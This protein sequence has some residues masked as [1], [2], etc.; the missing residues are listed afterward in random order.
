M[1]R[2][3]LGFHGVVISD[4]LGAAKQVSAYSPGQRAVK[5]VQAGGDMV[6]TVKPSTVPAMT[7]AL[8]ARARKVPAFKKKTDNAA[9]KVLQ[10]KHAAGLDPHQAGGSGR[11]T[12]GSALLTGLTYRVFWVGTNG[13]LE[14]TWWSQGRWH[15]Q[16][17]GGGLAAPVAATDHD[18]R[19]D[20]FGV[21]GGHKLWQRSY[22]PSGSWGRWHAI[23]SGFTGGVSAV[24]RGAAFHVF[25][26]DDA[27]HLLQAYWLGHGWR[28]QSLG[29]TTSGTPAA[30]LHG[31]QY[32]VFAV[33]PHGH[34][35]TRTYHSGSW[36]RW[37]SIATGMTPALTAV[38]SGGGDDVFGLGS[39]G[40]MLRLAQLGDDWAKSDIG[41][42]FDIGHGYHGPLG[43]TYNNGRFDAYG[44]AGAHV[45]HSRTTGGHWTGWGRAS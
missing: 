45:Y 9:L 33:S 21:S 8:V 26:H 30:T 4:D 25:G 35:F 44:K 23:A 16:S 31:G 24:R 36:S 2:S 40:H 14:Q 38:W 43:A 18:G 5:F 3:K 22:Y 42:R 28:K 13:R 7:R 32:D 39:D 15:T 19:I 11:H 10:A 12:G 41:G 20:V 27:G 1:L 6:L 17:L 37:H 34:V 29:G